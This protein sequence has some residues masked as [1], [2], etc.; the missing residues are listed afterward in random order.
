[1]EASSDRDIIADAYR[2]RYPQRADQ[3]DAIIAWL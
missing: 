2:E 3:L 1:M